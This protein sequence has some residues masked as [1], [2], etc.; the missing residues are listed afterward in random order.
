M[1]IENKSKF[2]ELLNKGVL[3]NYL[4]K[5]DRLD[6]V[7]SAKSPTTRFCSLRSRSKDSPHFVPNILISDIVRW[8]KE[9]NLNPRDFY[10]QEIPHYINCDGIGC[11]GCG[12]LANFEIARIEPHYLYM[13]AGCQPKLNLRH[14]LDRYGYDVYDLKALNKLKHYGIDGIVQDLFDSYPSAVIE[15]SVFE[16][17]VG[18]FN[19]K[20]VIWEVRDY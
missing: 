6:D 14:D 20:H 11:D 15:M 5:W 12:R 8:F 9:K 1:K 17:P 16:T 4:R 18:V 19:Q 2:L 3:G 7:L 13:R 10:F